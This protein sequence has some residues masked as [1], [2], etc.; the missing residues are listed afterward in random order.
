VKVENKEKVI[1]NEMHVDKKDICEA[2]IKSV[3]VEE[4]MEAIIVNEVQKEEDSKSALDCIMSVDL[5]QDKD[6]DFQPQ[7]VTSEVVV[8]NATYVI[9]TVLDLP[10]NTSS[11][12]DI[13]LKTNGISID[14][15]NQDGRK[16]DLMNAIKLQRVHPNDDNSF[17]KQ[18][19]GAKLS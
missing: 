4:S 7:L 9:T 12:S 16:I 15:T 18:N 13:S 10:N 19:S 17:I 6:S 1:D 3:N 14:A 2:D 5:T 8:G 11:K